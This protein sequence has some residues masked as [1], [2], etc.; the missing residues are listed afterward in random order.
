[1]E[2][3]NWAILLFKACY[4]LMVYVL[5]TSESFKKCFIRLASLCNTFFCIRHHCP[6]NGKWT[7]ISHAGIHGGYLVR[8]QNFVNGK[9]FRTTCMI[10]FCCDSGCC[11]HK[12]FL[13]FH[14]GIFHKSEHECVKP[15]FEATGGTSPPKWELEHE[16]IGVFTSS[17]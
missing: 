14:T 9:P 15:V 12:E 6:I 11:S 4:N 3:P 10:F 5:V 13:A 7:K 16:H 2:K 1:M 8:T 17:M